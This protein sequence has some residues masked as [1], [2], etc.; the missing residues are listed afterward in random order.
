MDINELIK[1][2]LRLSYYSFLIGTGL[3]VLFFFT[4]SYR[5]A[6]YSLLVILILGVGNLIYF[7]R[8]GKHALV[9]KET[10]KQALKAGGIM[11][12]NIPVVLIYMYLFVVLNNTVIVRLKNVSKKPLTNIS[13]MGC[14]ER[15]ISDL[16]PGET[17]IEWIPITKSCMLNSITLQYEVNGIITKEVVYGYVIDGQRINHRIGQHK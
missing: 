8:L 9:E 7:W 4:N 16:L 11:L 5:L 15:T 12:V 10:R 6:S 3:F 14:D 17:D 1:K 2:S 13:V